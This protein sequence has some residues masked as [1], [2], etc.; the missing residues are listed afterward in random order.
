MHNPLPDADSPPPSSR[1]GGKRVLP[2]DAATLIIVRRDGPQPRLLMG[3]RHHGH[4]FM[5]GKWV[6]P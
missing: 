1:G 4:D 5:P 3:R 6:F 2:R